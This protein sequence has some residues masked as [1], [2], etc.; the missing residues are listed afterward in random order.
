MEASA[1]SPRPN[2][3]A[4]L[5]T[6]RGLLIVRF[7]A[8]EVGR[9]YGY[10]GAP[11][12]RAA[13]AVAD[14]IA[15]WEWAAWR[16]R[17]QGRLDLST[18]ER[19]GKLVEPEKN[20]EGFRSCAV[21]VGVTVCPPAA[22]IRGLLREWL[23]Q[24]AMSVGSTAAECAYRRFQEIHPFRDGNGRVGKII[25]NWLLGTLDAPQMPPNFWGIGNP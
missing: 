10:P 17:E 12:S 3:E 19:L 14:M 15:A 1:G 5:F 4:E 8:E 9:Q 24:Y 21:R 6:D 11:A 18:L 2:N 25:F 22:E 23:G 7:C 13:E 16:R 20:A